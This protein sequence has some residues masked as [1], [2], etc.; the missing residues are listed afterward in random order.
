MY[1]HLH[2][3]ASYLSKAH[4]KSHSSGT[5]LLSSKPIDPTMTPPPTT[6]P[7]P[8]NGAIHTTISILRNIMASVT[9][10]ELTV[11]FHNTPDA[12]PL[13]TALLEMG[14]PQSATPINNKN[15]C[16]AGIT[17]EKVKQ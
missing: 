9:E 11:L 10:A 3:D 6:R 13:H 4:T 17:N 7:P 15:A 2:S 14:H 1:L 12:V 5:F 8:H 16:A